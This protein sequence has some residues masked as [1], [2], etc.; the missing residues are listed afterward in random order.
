MPS[1]APWRKPWRRPNKI[2]AIAAALHRHIANHST[3]MA[4]QV[5]KLEEISG[6]LENLMAT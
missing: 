5:E 4:G 6:E 3:E 2:A 1:C